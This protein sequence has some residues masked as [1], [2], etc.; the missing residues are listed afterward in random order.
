MRYIR[1]GEIALDSWARVEGD[2]PVPDDV[3]AI[4][5][6]DW[7]LSTKPEALRIRKAPLGVSWP[8][9]KGE[10][11]LAPY[12]PALSLIVLE[13]PVFRDGRAYTQARQ[14][15][16]RYGFKG[17]IRA[18]GDVLRDQFFFMV[19]AGFDAF[20]VRKDAD[21]AHFAAALRELT[22]QYQ[23]AADGRPPIFRK[24]LARTIGA[25]NIEDPS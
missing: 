16:E 3:A 10:N 24:R 18:T 4:V 20:E 5:S 1:N 12:L 21:A 22:L 11:A 17:E 23:P 13:F 8:N 2:E 6:A 9:D 19:R 15:R 7:L 25:Q 14:L